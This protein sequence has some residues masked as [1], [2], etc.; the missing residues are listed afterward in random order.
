M[1]PDVVVRKFNPNLSERRCTDATTCTAPKRWTLVRYTQV[2][3][4]GVV[5]H[6]DGEA[7]WFSTGCDDHRDSQLADLRRR[8]GRDL[9]VEHP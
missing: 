1:A 8:V 9:E 3:R 4:D 6:S 2:T 5:E 7:F